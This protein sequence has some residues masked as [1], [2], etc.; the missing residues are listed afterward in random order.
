LTAQIYWA[1][2][3]LRGVSTSA[4]NKKSLEDKSAWRAA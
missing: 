3:G 2:C 4:Q 1:L